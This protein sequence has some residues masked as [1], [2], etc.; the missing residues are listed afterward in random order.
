MGHDRKLSGTAEHAPEHSVYARALGSRLRAV[1][2]QTGLTLL[3]VEALSKREYGAAVV[4]SYER[5]DRVITVARL[6]GLAKLYNVPVDQLF[7]AEDLGD[8]SPSDGGHVGPVPSHGTGDKRDHVTIDL[9]GL[10][11]ADIGSE[12][13]VLR[14]FVNMIQL[15]RQDFNGRIITIRARDL[16][17]IGLYLDLATDAVRRRLEDLNLLVTM[18]PSRENSSSGGPQPAPV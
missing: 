11:S 16:Q 17:A 3:G 12:R 4:G 7:P 6:L 5:G 13:E 8:I 2:H 9:V 1:R 15:Q 10:K 18:G 14:R